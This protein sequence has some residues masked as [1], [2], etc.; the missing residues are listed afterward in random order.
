MNEAREFFVGFQSKPL[1]R[2]AI[3]GDPA[4]Q[5]ARAV[6]ERGRRGDDVHG[7][8]ARRQFLLPGRH[9]GMRLCETNH[10]D[11]EGCVGEPALLDIDLVWRGLRVFP[12]ENSRD[13]LAAAGLRVALDH[14]K[15]PWRQLAVIWN[16]R[17]KGPNGFEFGRRG[18]GLAHL[19]RFYRAAGFE[20]FN[21]VGHCRFLCRERLGSF[22]LWR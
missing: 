9:L 4:A 18:A 7:A 22:L 10:A 12:R 21:G 1:E 16:P 5:P 14:D 20:E 3:D 8:G 2:V 13:Y 6:A 19:A 11:Y 17:A 15:R